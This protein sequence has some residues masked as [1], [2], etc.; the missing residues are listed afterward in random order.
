MLIVIFGPTGSGKSTL[1]RALDKASIVREIEIITTRPSRTNDPGRRTVPEYVYDEM[2]ADDQLMW[3]NEVDG[4]RY[5]APRNDVEDAAATST[6]SHALDFA[7]EYL[8]KVESLPGYRAGILLMP[9]RDAIETRLTNSRRASR[10]S[11]LD[12]QYGYYQAQVGSNSLSP[13]INGRV[14]TSQDFKAVLGEVI[15]I[16]DKLGRPS[17]AP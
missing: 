9:P 5:G 14:I 2:Q 15:T 4:F 11:L 10:L 13:V 17:A 12:Q 3:S 6:P 16:L 8:Q 7:L 1:I